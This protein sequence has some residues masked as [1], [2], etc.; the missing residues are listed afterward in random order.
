MTES[1]VLY[2]PK[3]IRDSFGRRMK[4][5]AIAKAALFFPE[6]V[7]YKD[8]LKSLNLIREELIMKIPD[9][10]RWSEVDE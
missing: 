4:I 8:V 9:W 6:T 3:D 5:L 2:V 10:E 1:G 7:D